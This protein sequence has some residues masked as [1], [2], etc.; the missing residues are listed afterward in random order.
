MGEKSEVLESCE[1]NDRLNANRKLFVST[2]QKMRL[3]H[4]PM[5]LGFETK[6]GKSCSKCIDPKVSTLSPFDLSMENGNS[7]KIP[8]RAVS[9]CTHTWI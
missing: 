6:L 8:G 4:L 5:H 1:L 9:K 7:A 3:S 2:C